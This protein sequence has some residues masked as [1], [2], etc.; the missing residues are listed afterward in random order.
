MKK[1]KFFHSQ[2]RKSVIQHDNNSLQKEQLSNA[3]VSE[4]QPAGKEDR[5]KNELE[6]ELIMYPFGKHENELTEFK[7]SWSFAPSNSKFTQSKNIMIAVCA[8]LNNNGGIIYI[9]VDDSGKIVGVDGDLKNGNYNGNL[10]LFVRD[11]QDLIAKERF[12]KNEHQ[13]LNTK[14]EY[15]VLQGKPIVTITVYPLEKG[16]AKVD[17]IAYVR[18]GAENR[19]MNDIFIQQRIDD[20]KR[21]EQL[22][23]KMNE[24]QK[25]KISQLRKAIAEKKMVVLEN[26]HSGNSNTTRNRHLEVFE[27]LDDLNFVMAYDVEETS[28]DKPKNKQFVLNRAERIVILD[29]HWL[30]ENKHIP[31]LKD[32]F[33]LSAS[34]EI[35]PT[36]VKLRLSTSARNLLKEEYRNAEK[37]LTKEDDSHWILETTVYNLKGIGRFCLGLL[38]DITILEGQ[39]LK[40][41]ILAYLMRHIGKLSSM[42]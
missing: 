40:D 18:W 8:L 15:K 33:N 19:E 42:P 34:A 35:E 25:N 22:L 7:E 12:F 29:S 28:P 4:E 16:V 17:G 6:D 1:H 9:G 24:S 31:K 13:Y 23:Q 38:D 36:H 20:L 41:Y 5:N 21:R 37:Y 39:V 32:I 27:I 30:N 10:E 3:V 2:K 26:Y 14:V 11:I